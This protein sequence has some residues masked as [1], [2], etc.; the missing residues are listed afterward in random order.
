MEIWNNIVKNK[1][2]RAPYAGWFDIRRSTI[3]GN[4]TVRKV[5]SSKLI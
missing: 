5:F 3:S 2:E 1:N 4:F